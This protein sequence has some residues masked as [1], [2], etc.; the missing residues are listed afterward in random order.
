MLLDH[1]SFLG[2]LTF[3][4]WSQVLELATEKYKMN[5]WT[6]HNVFFSIYLLGFNISLILLIGM[7]SLYNKD[8]HVLV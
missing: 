8:I 3:V 2:L 4:S 5:V 1:K 7:N 6:T